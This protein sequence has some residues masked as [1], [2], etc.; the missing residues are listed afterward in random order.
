VSYL[1]VVLCSDTSDMC[2]SRSRSNDQSL[3]YRQRLLHA[4]IQWLPGTMM[5]ECVIVK[6]AVSGGINR[7]CFGMRINS[8]RLSLCWCLVSEARNYIICESAAH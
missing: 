8:G 1:S 2:F 4:T 5:Q 7:L 6:R 3:Y